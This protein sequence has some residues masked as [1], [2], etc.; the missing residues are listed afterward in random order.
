[1]KLPSA[2]EIRKFADEKG[3]G[4]TEASKILTKQRVIWEATVATS[5]DELKDIILWMLT[6]T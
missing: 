3:L 4:I 6:Y 2:E 1:M 5:V